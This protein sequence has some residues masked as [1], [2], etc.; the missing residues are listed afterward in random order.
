LEVFTALHF[1]LQGYTDE[2]ISKI[3]SNIGESDIVQLDRWELKVE[4]NP[5]AEANEEGKENLP[6]NVVNN[7]FSL[8]VDAH[9]ALEF[10]EARG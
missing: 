8:G 3:L 1:I 6:L 7:Y 2:P 9:I 10:H 5:D 4:K